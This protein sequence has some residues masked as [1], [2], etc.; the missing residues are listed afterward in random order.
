MRLARG[1]HLLDL[2]GGGPTGAAEDRPPLGA[3]V[4]AWLYDSDY[5]DTETAELERRRNETLMNISG[6]RDENATQTEDD[7]DH[8]GASTL[9][10]KFIVGT[11]SGRAIAVCQDCHND[12]PIEALCEGRACCGRRVCPR[13]SRADCGW[14]NLERQTAPLVISIANCLDI[15][16]VRDAT[17]SE[18]VLAAASGARAAGMGDMSGTPEHTSYAWGEVPTLTHDDTNYFATGSRLCSGCG[19][20]MDALH[21]SWRICRCYALYCA[22]CAAGP[23]VDCPAV[24]VYIDPETEGHTN[25]APPGTPCDDECKTYAETPLRLSPEEASNRRQRMMQ[26]QEVG[27]RRDKMRHRQVR[28]GQ[29]RRGTRPKRD[30]PG[31]ERVRF[32]SAN[33]TAEST[34]RQEHTNGRTLKKVDYLFIQEHGQHGDERVDATRK[35]IQA[36]GADAVVD[37]AYVKNAGAGGGTAI[38]SHADGGLRRL[39]RG[40]E[41]AIGMTSKGRASIGIGSVGYDFTCVSLY[42]IAG[43]SA[44][45]Q[46]SLWKDIAKAIKRLGLPFVIGGDWQVAPS[47]VAASG[48]PH[49]LN[50]VICAPNCATNAVS[51]TT[52]DF[53]LISKSMAAQG[54]DITVDQD[55]VFSPH[56]AVMLDIQIRRTRATCQ[57]LAKPRSYPPDIPHGP[58]PAGIIIEWGEYDQGQN[59]E[60]NLNNWYAGIECEVATMYGT[61]GTEDEVAYMGMGLTPRLVSDGA[62]GRFRNVPDELGLI[63]QRLTWVSRGLAVWLRVGNRISNGADADKLT[64]TLW[65]IGHRAIAFACEEK[66]RKHTE[67]LEHFQSSLKE[68]LTFMATWS[69]TVR[70]ARPAI[71]R[72]INGDTN[73]RQ[74]L[75]AIAELHETTINDALSKLRDARLARKTKEVGEWCRAATLKC[76]HRIT[77]PLELPCGYSASATKHHRGERTAQL[78]AN[79]GI[80]EW[81]RVWRACDVT[82]PDD[83]EEILSM[84]EG[85]EG[86]GPNEA[87]EIQLPPI[88]AASIYH[89]TRT[90]RNNTG[91]GVDW[92]PPR[93]VSKTSHG[94]RSFLASILT[95]VERARRW[96][97]GVRAVIE[98][99]R[100]K[101]AGGARLIGLAPSLYRIWSRIRYTQ[102]RGE[103]EKRIARP[104]L[105]AAPG[106]GALRAVQEAAWKC[107]YA[108]ARNEHAAATTADLRQYYEQIDMAEVVRGAKSHGLPSVVTILAVDL[109]MGPR[110]IKVDSSYSDFV[111][112]K[113]S[114]LAGCTWAM[115]FIRLMMIIPSERF[116]GIVRRKA[117]EWGALMDLTMYVD[118]GVLVTIGHMDAVAYLHEWASRLLLR[119]ITHVL[120]KETAEGKLHCITSS[121]PLRRRLARGLRDDGFKVDNY[122]ELLGVGFAAGGQMRSRS[123]N[124]ARL[125][126]ALRRKNRLKW[127][128]DNGGRASRVVRDG[129]RPA[130]NYEGSVSGISDRTMLL[131]RRAQGATC[132]IRCG[133]ASL[134]ARLAVGGEEFED[135]D[136]WV[137]DAALPVR[138]IL[139]II[140]D[141]PQRR[142]ELVRMWRLASDEVGNAPATERWRRVR[143]MVGACMAHVMRAGGRWHKPFTMNLLGCDI[144][145]LRTPP[146][147]VEYVLQRQARQKLDVDLVNRIAVEYGWDSNNIRNHYRHGIDW[148]QVRCMLRGSVGN[149]SGEERHAYLVLLSGAFWTEWKR[150]TS[151]YSGHAS[152]AACTWEMGSLAHKIIG[153]SS[154]APYMSQQVAKGRIRG[155]GDPVV[156]EGLEPLHLLGLPPLAVQVA[157]SE[158]RY[159]EG[160][161]S[162]DWEGLSFGDGSGHFQH[163][164]QCRTATWAVIRRRPNEAVPFQRKRGNV[165]GWMRTVARGEIMAYLNHLMDLGPRGTYVGDCSM[166]VR[167]ARDGVP[168]QARSSGNVNADL[169]REVHQLQQDRKAPTVTARKTKAHR[170]RAAAEVDPDD[171]IEMW[172]GN[173]LADQHA[174]ELSNFIACSS[175]EHRTL[176]QAREAAVE[177]ITRAAIAVSWNLRQWPHLGQTKTRKRRRATRGGGEDTNGHLLN[178]REAN[179]WEC[180]RCRLWARGQQGRRALLR[181]PCRGRLNKAAHETHS[182]TQ[183]NGIVWCR[184]CGAF[185]SR[186]L[187][188]LLR[189]CSG[190][191]GSEAQRNVRRRLQAGLAPTTADYLSAERTTSRQYHQDE[192]DSGAPNDGGSL[193][194]TDHITIDDIRV[195]RARRRSLREN[196]ASG[197]TTGIYHGMYL[198]L[199][200]GPLWQGRAEPVL[201]NAPSVD[202]ATSPAPMGPTDAPQDQRNTSAAT[203]SRATTLASTT[204]VSSRAEPALSRH[205]EDQL[206]RSSCIRPPTSRL[207]QSFAASSPAICVPTPRCSWTRRITT[208]PAGH[209]A[210]MAQCTICKET[211][212]TFCRGCNA[213]V[214]ASCA[215][216]RRSCSATSTVI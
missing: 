93:L 116:L 103:L 137:L 44:T 155:G 88:D 114:V 9:P 111:R 84:L 110:C 151:G 194:G 187:R 11:N 163:S 60:Y 16:D 172:E 179:A 141:Q 184:R 216:S 67:E 162:H 40:E 75:T 83:T 117:L 142:G 55:C 56:K 27:R 160:D 102:I 58:T 208:G 186:L 164:H 169:W 144:D 96:P 206:N 61:A 174:K 43:A 183:T 7:H 77:R 53:F 185:S 105:A 17:E 86:E 78:A 130:V 5:E 202:V 29:I 189:P 204:N 104:F 79:A 47:V 168:I 166:V 209:L 138:A 13:C 124:A 215:R 48:L 128:R 70:G 178:I 36:L 66:R 38:V 71:A 175:F 8:Q 89:G 107:E 69:R 211:C 167:Y 145:I 181:H 157:P 37:A 108:A 45:Q 193:D 149:L 46:L 188:N 82:D 19:I 129:W 34:W 191:P 132:R 52:I 212:R 213:H 154:M 131:T 59:I 122:G 210:A 118:D 14:C 135:V 176:V 106:R 42:G 119:W 21:E 6:G 180:S 92:L 90:F 24:Q 95:A 170:S 94:A 140:W 192:A 63:G 10:P 72:W 171:P 41:D 115:V 153:C 62:C 182:V 159:V 158:M 214:C 80:K 57:R 148:E 54:W 126:K 87:N 99:A 31:R 177:A 196:A 127:L 112:P 146:K 120:H 98:L 25:A 125:R 85:I 121:S 152:C 143:G 49:L 50:G 18:E 28:E 136:P 97:R 20:S 199:P 123:T 190:A 12:T 156:P 150:W 205:H 73:T 81:G 2:R 195:R 91:V 51:G 113:R 200:G 207:S 76:A 68:A 197:S 64:D 134:T 173:R 161:L 198:R 109:Y 74:Q 33:V 23:C 147:Q 133:G 30:K 201:H 139:N 15:V 100:A 1:S 3:G 35:W 4:L 203:S 22:A 101:K 65:R 39:S 165:D 32:G 26:E